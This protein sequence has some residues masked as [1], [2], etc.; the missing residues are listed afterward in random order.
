MA[1][2]FR[3]DERSHSPHGDRGAVTIHAAGTKRS[4]PKRH[5]G[6]PNSTHRGPPAL[7][8]PRVR[9]AG[10]RRRADLD[11]RTTAGENWRPPASEIPAAIRA[12]SAASFPALAV[13]GPK[14]WIAGSPGTLV[15]HSDDGGRMDRPIDRPI[16]ADR[17]ARLRRRFARLGRR[18]AGCN[19]CHRRRRADLAAAARR[20]RSC[21]PDGHLRR[22]ERRAA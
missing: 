3:P 17:V 8:R 5:S 14:V 10:R 7:L 18:R 6:V 9:L 16:S 19:P 15:F 21:G 20:W 12:L 4:P 13:R 22:S 2:S 1:I 11:T